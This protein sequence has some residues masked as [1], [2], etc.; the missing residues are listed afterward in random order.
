LKIICP[1]GTLSTL[2]EQVIIDSSYREIVE[3]ILPQLDFFI[4]DTVIQAKEVSDYLTAK[5]IGR[6][7]FLIK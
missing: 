2:R 3:T 4:V 5:R 7:T 1:D 6:M